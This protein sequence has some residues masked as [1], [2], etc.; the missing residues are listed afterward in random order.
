[1][2]TTAAF[3]DYLRDKEEVRSVLKEAEQEKNFLYLRVLVSDYRAGPLRKGAGAVLVG[4]VKGRAREL[5]K[6]RVFLDCFGGNGSQ[7]VK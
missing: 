6:K 1:M 3:A 5:G 4:H 7:L 2:A